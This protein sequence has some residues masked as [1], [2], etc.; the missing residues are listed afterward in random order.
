VIQR[1]WLIYE[2]AKGKEAWRLEILKLK[3]QGMM[4]NINKWNGKSKETH[5]PITM[6][7]VG[8]A[9]P[10]GTTGGRTWIPTAFPP[11]HGGRS[12]KRGNGLNTKVNGGTKVKEID[13]YYRGNRNKRSSPVAADILR[14]S[15]GRVSFSSRQLLALHIPVAA[16]QLNTE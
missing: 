1:P 7:L 4:R 15:R 12:G 10:T 13:K 5:V 6:A 3:S 2:T 11:A 16:H 9:L 8:V 14:Q